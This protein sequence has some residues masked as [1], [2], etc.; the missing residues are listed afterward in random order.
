MEHSLKN[1][2]S[3]FDQ[4]LQPIALIEEHLRPNQ[5][6]SLSTEA[7]GISRLASLS[8]QPQHDPAVPGCIRFELLVQRDDVRLAADGRSAAPPN[9]V[10]AR[11]RSEPRDLCVLLR[12]CVP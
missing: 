12:K 7:S 9:D 5:S 2:L 6:S 4:T 1:F 10:T 3:Q 8:Q 11:F